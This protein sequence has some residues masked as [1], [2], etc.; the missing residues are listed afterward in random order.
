MHAPHAAGEKGAQCTAGI[1][2]KPTTAASQLLIRSY[3]PMSKQPTR[4]IT[5]AHVGLARTSGTGTTH[6]GHSAREGRTRALSTVHLA[7]DSIDHVQMQLY[8]NGWRHIASR[9]LLAC[10]CE[11]W[12]VLQ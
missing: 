1:K 10:A 12:Q 9:P 3:T 2:D 4:C 8:T 6:A 7:G 5:A 11:K